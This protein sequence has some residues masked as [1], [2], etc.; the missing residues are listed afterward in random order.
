MFE[1]KEEFDR[2]EPKAKT[3]LLRFGFQSES[4]SLPC[5]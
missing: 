2:H 1:L 3:G 5:L 4:L